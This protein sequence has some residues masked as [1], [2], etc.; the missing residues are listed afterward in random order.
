MKNK[1]KNLILFFVLLFVYSCEQERITYYENKD[2]SEESIYQIL[3]KDGR[4]TYYV[5]VLDITKFAELLDNTGSF[6]AFPPTDDA[7]EKYLKEYQVSFESLDKEELRKIAAYSFTDFA[8]PFQYLTTKSEWGFWARG[9]NTAFKKKT[10]Y[11]L[12]PYDEGDYRIINEPKYLHI[13]TNDYFKAAGGAG[14]EAETY[15]YFY[16]NTV[17]NANN[18]GVNVANSNVVKA[19]IPAKNGFI[20]MVDKVLIPPQNIAEIISAKPQHDEFGLLFEKF[21]EYVFSQS[22]TERR[23]STID[24]YFKKYTGSK[25]RELNTPVAELE[26][27]INEENVRGSYTLQAPTYSSHTVFIPNNTALATHLSKYTGEPSRPALRHLLN[28]HLIKELIQYPYH[29]T[30]QGS[31]FKYLFDR[32]VVTSAELASNGAI[33]YVNR[34]YIE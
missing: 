5:K 2:N 32:G 33:Y 24:L 13:F 19:D 30:M 4:F 25:P 34:H 9:D 27:D 26:V 14:K 11:S 1:L 31:P 6:T 23:N 12:P 18:L 15:N 29:L 17:W 3:K 10:R 7:F 20:Y 28:A 22:E 16:P 8:L 21:K